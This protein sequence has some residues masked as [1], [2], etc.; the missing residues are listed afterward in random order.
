MAHIR[1]IEICS[2]IF[3]PRKQQGN[4]IKQIQ[5]ISNYLCQC[6]IFFTWY[7]LVLTLQSGE[8]ILILQCCV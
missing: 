6:P 5:L 7:S 4:L 3:S 1:E 8:D 2:W